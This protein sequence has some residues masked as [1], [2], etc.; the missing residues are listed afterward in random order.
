MPSLATRLIDQVTFT[1]NLAVRSLALAL[2]FLLKRCLYEIEELL[3]WPLSYAQKLGTAR[4]SWGPRTQNGHRA[5]KLGTAHAENQ[6][7]TNIALK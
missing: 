3:C 6:T 5:R 1:S 4:A 7:E 2:H